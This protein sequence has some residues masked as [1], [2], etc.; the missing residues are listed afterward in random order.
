MVVQP[1]DLL[2]V[3]VDCQGSAKSKE[4][5][6]SR[7]NGARVTRAAGAPVLRYIALDPRH[8]SLSEIFSCF[9]C[10]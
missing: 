8:E 2:D 3:P 1:L 7:V 9:K 6:Q 5:S 4:L 10:D